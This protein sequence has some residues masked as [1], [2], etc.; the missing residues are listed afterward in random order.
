MIIFFL[1]TWDTRNKTH[2]MRHMKCDTWC[3]VKIP[4]KCQLSSYNGLGVMMLWRSWGK[5]WLTYEMQRC[6]EDI[7]RLQQVCKLYVKNILQIID[8]QKNHPLCFFFVFFWKFCVFLYFRFLH[9]TASDNYPFLRGFC[10]RIWKSK[11]MS[12]NPAKTCQE[13]WPNQ[14]PTVFNVH[15]LRLPK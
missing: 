13:L 11:K 12:G 9:Q 5:G 8:R 15:P 1:W 2:E 4:S 3:W 7:P 6:L 14:S 10:L